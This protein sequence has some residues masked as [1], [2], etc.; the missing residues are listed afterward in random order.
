[1]FSLLRLAIRIAGVVTIASFSLPYF[2]YEPNWDFWTE[3]KEACDEVFSGCRETL[4]RK[5]TE[6][7]IERCPVGK[8]LDP[9]G[10]VRKRK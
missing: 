9:R 7:A 1:M 4:I 5:G 6:G 3:R 2:G 8:C 10:L